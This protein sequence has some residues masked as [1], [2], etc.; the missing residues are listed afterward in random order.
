M[1]RAGRPSALLKS[2]QNVQASLFV[3]FF[4]LMSPAFLRSPHSFDPW[5]IFKQV[6]SEE[7]NFQ[8]NTLEPE[9]GHGKRKA[10]CAQKDVGLN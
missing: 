5:W 8:V 10:L 1:L 2:L 4:L 9:A 3:Q 7:L 6:R